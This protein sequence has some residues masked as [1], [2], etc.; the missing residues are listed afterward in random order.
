MG[1]GASQHSNG[2]TCK[3][4]YLAGAEIDESL[5]REHYQVLKDLNIKILV[6][7]KYFLFFSSFTILVKKR[8]RCPTNIDAD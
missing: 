5:K 7:K 2:V 4:G 6:I 3:I 1:V 8:C